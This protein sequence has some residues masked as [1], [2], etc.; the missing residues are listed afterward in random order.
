[1]GGSEA[2]LRDLGFLPVGTGN[3]DL[4]SLSLRIPEALSL[5][6]SVSED[7]RVG[8]RE[9]HIWAVVCP[10][11]RSG[12][13]SELPSGLCADCCSPQESGSCVWSS[14]WESSLPAGPAKARSYPWRLGSKA[15]GQDWDPSPMEPVLTLGVMWN[16]SASPSASI[17]IVNIGSSHRMAAQLVHTYKHTC[18]HTYAH[19]H[20]L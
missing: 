10:G 4:Q 14:P 15:L 19:T 5:P 1:M 13:W 18:M 2:R 3:T 6:T 16:P 11:Q 12:I 17:N 8:F 20:M 7:S 9:G